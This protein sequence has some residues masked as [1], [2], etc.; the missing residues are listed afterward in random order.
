M[1]PLPVPSPVFKDALD[2]GQNLNQV[3]VQ[4][5]AQELEAKQA[6]QDY[7]RTVAEASLARFKADPESFAHLK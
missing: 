5:L 7:F 3:S 1:S 6:S 4:A 2:Q